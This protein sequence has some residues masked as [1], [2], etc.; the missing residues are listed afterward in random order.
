M[1]VLVNDDQGGLTLRRLRPWQ[2]L[3][4]YAGTARLDRA[5]ADGANPEASV[6]LAARAARLTSTKFRGDLAAGLR[7]VLLA[8]ALPVL[9]AGVATSRGPVATAHPLRAPLRSARIRQSAPVLAEL[10]SRLLEPGPVPVQGVAMVTELLTN[11]AG[12]LYRDAA[13]KAPKVPSD[14]D[15]PDHLAVL[16]TRAAHALTW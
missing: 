13:P 5:L 3:V 4:A 8:A 16:A 12:P 9:P 7:R 15:T 10:A 2:R 11:G 14:P 6:A 1:H